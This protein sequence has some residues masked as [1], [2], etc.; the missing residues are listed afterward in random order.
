MRAPDF[1][2]ADGFAPRLLSPLAALYGA[3]ARRRLRR[4]APH[5]ALP[6]IVVGG[7]TAGGDGKTPLAMALASC[8]TCAGER[9]AL[10]TRGYGGAGG[11][12]PFAVDAARDEAEKVGDEALL[13]AGH[14]LTIVGADRL[15]GAAL[16]AS[17]GA[18]ALILDDGFHSRRLAGDLSLLVID[19]DYGA[20]NGRCIPAGPLRAPLDAQFA[21]ADALVVIGDGAAGRSLADRS[22]KSVFDARIVADGQAAGAL[23][24]ARV[25]AFAGI[26]RPDKFFRTLRETGADIVSAKSYA[27]HHCFGP[28]DIAEL[29]DLQRRHDARLVTTEKDAMRLRKSGLPVIVLPISLA[30]S[31]KDR[32]MTIVSAALQRARLSRAS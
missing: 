23:A 28:D 30:I 7:L 10:L 11:K 15:A 9:P 22:G 32:L 26:G 4:D 14:G 8:L 21:A 24:G 2:R 31:E 17:L 13:L 5:A 16:A 1:W 3:A 20:G 6:T 25:C 12:Q 18:T 27:D 29:R 19:A